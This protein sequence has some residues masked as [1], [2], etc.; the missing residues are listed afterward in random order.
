MKNSVIAWIAGATAL[1]SAA[2]M[3]AASIATTDVT[4]VVDGHST[5]LRVDSATVNTLLAQRDIA[6]GEHDEVTP[7]PATQL[8]DGMTITVQYGR[9]FDITIDGVSQTKWAVGTTV[10]G[11]LDDLGLTDPDNDVSPLR[12]TPVTGDGVAI[13]VNTPKLATVTVDGQSMTTESTLNSV[14]A[15]LS[16]QGITLGPDDRVTPD[17]TTALTD[18]IQIMVQRVTTT[19]ETDPRAV[20]RHPT[21]KPERSRR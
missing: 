13:V 14:G 20:W 19:Q 17:T 8:T 11:V 2:G 7:A 3:G 21:A 16:A 18:G 4:L 1:V 5:S 10:G 9:Q 6:V 12:T 15:L